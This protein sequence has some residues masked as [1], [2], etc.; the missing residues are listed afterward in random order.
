MAKPKYDGFKPGACKNTYTAE[1]QKASATICL[2]DE[3][4]VVEVWGESVTV[5]PQPDPIT[6]KQKDDANLAAKASADAALAAELAK[7]KYDG[8][9]P[10][11]C[12]N[13]YT[14]EAQKASATI[15]LVDETILVEVWGE[16]VTVGPQ[17]DPITQ[18][19]KDDANLAAKASADAAL[20]AELAK[21]KYDGFTPGACKN[22]YTAEAQKA[23]ATICLVDETIL[24]EVWGESVTVGP[25]P[26]PITQKQKDDANLA[27]KASADAALA[28]ELALPKYDGFTPGECKNT[29]T[30]VAVTVTV[31]VC[32]LDVTTTVSATGESVTVGPQPD[33]ITAEQ[34]AAANL[35]AQ[36]SAAAA[37]DKKLATEYPGFVP[38]TCVAPEPFTAVA[39][40][41]RVLDICYD[42]AEIAVSVTGSGS[43]SSMTS[44]VE[45]QN[46][47]NAAAT[48][49]VN[50]EP[51]GGAGE[52][53]GLHRGCL[54]RAADRGGAGC[55]A[56]DAGRRGGAGVG[57]GAGD[58]PGS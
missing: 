26:D 34:K 57:H 13:T 24:V 51:G 29:Y 28:A 55:G 21:P 53:P 6:Q 50:A 38:G 15:C 1:A 48:A 31:T 12:K 22:T 41:A 23:S 10:G 8:F 47:A 49:Q 42:G 2:V 30:A 43:G 56:G 14:A 5:G 46:Q 33:P 40:T 39:S 37:L 16:S 58:G 45:A 19:Q 35:A 7:P 36:N 18:K 3:T 9:T 4:I 52:V 27:A 11:A 25:Q 44:Q 54:H 20:A 17:P 32:Y